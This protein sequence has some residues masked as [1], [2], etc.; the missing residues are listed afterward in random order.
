[1]KDY[2]YMGFDFRL[3]DNILANSGRKLYEIDELKPAGTRPFLTSINDVREFIRDAVDMGYW[4]DG[5]GW[6]HI[7]PHR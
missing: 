6:T 2:R 5:A 7:T 1:M 3:T 4:I